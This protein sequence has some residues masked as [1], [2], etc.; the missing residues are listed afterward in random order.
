[1][2]RAGIETGETVFAGHLNFME[3]PAIIILVSN[4]GIDW[5]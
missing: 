3:Q 2:R 4:I 1:M 5:Y